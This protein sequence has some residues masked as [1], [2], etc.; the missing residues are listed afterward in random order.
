MN[1]SWTWG[2]QS[3]SRTQVSILSQHLR[4]FPD[5]ALRVSAALECPEE[6][7]F[8]GDVIRTEQRMFKKGPKKH[9]L[10]VYRE[11]NH[12]GLLKGGPEDKFQQVLLDTLFSVSVNSVTSFICAFSGWRA[13]LWFL[14]LMWVETTQ[15]YKLELLRRASRENVVGFV[16]SPA[17]QGQSSEQPL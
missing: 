15:G 10:C 11:G 6:I 8:C 14:N 13:G 3:F 17:I 1:T 12:I 16:W 2:P 9:T 5:Q 7:S 4:C